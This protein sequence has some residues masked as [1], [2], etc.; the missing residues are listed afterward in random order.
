MNILDLFII[1]VGGCGLPLLAIVVGVA[2]PV[3]YLRAAG[4]SLGVALI[5]ATGFVLFG[6]DLDELVTLRKTGGLGRGFVVG[7]GMLFGF[8]VLV[9]ISMAKKLLRS[10]STDQQKKHV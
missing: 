9:F 6:G 3:V 1:A 8:S 7:I 2:Q 10:A 5:C 4:L